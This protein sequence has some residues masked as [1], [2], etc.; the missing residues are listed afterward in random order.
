MLPTETQDR[1]AKLSKPIRDVPPAV[2]LD[3]SE[4]SELEMMIERLEKKSDSSEPSSGPSAQRDPFDPNVF[5][6]KYR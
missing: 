1:N 4:L 5:N 6:Q 3:G 2:F